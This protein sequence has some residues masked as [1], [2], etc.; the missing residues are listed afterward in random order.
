MIALSARERVE[1]K[2]AHLA[3]RETEAVRRNRDCLEAYVAGIEPD[4]LL[5]PTGPCPT[6]APRYRSPDGR[7]RSTQP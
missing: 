4:R 5:E 1:L 7:P 2:Y 3:R 6:I